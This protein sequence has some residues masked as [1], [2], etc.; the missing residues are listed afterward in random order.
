MIIILNSLSG[1]FLMST[2]VSS[3]S[4]VLSC[5]FIWNTFLCLLVFPSS[6]FIPLCFIGQLHLPILEKQPYVRDIL[7]APGIYSSLVI[8]SICSSSF[9]YVGCVGP[10]VVV[11]LN[12][13][14][15]LVGGAGPGQ[16][17]CQTL[18]H[19]VAAGPPVGR[20]RTLQAG[21]VVLEGLGW[22]QPNVA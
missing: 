16:F 1:I 3:F 21:S 9:P 6:L 8:K 18:I 2:L 12:T 4:R 7:W 15:M 10:S 17:V 19:I 11:G 20:A 5:S 22:C 13:L 14:G